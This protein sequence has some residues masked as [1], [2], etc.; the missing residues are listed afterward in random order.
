MFLEALKSVNSRTDEGAINVFVETPKGSRHKYDLDASGLFRIAIEL[1]EGE[2]FPFSFGY[3]PNTKAP[4]GDPVDI[5]LVTA[6]SVPS[7]A[8]IEARLIGVLKMEND[9]DGKMARNDRIVAVAN[10]S[11]IFSNI[12]TLGDMRDGFAWDIEL[13]FQNYNR[14]IERPFNIVGRGEREEAYEMLKAAEAA[15]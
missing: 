13:F 12:E 6:G 4:D 11:R 14:M 9:E 15:F 5:V 2:S 8:L 1:P 7:G 10:M 3:V